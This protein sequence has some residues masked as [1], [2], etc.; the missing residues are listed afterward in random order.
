MEIWKSSIGIDNHNPQK[1]YENIA[2]KFFKV[3]I[4]N[5]YAFCEKFKKTYDCTYRPSK[6]TI[7]LQLIQECT[8]IKKLENGNE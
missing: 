6:F 7:T 4:A 5:Q 1:Y 2:N 8:T 3:L